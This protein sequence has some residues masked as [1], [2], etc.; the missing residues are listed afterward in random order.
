V[1][2]VNGKY[3]YE[4]LIVITDEQANSRN[5]IP[6]PTGKG[7]VINVSTNKNGVG[8]GAWTHIDGWSEHV[9]HYLT[10]VEGIKPVAKKTIEPK[11]KK[12]EAGTPVDWKAYKKAKLSKPKAKAKKTPKRK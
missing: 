5:S 3:K 7:Y 6:E 12:I 4:R 8:Y 2:Y 9:I 11:T 1:K 10:I